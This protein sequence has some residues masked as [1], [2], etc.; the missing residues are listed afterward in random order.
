MIFACS[1]CGRTMPQSR[2]ALEIA[3]GWTV[4]RVEQHNDKDVSIGYLYL[5]PNDMLDTKS[6][7]VELSLKTTTQNSDSN[8][9]PKLQ[10]SE[11][12]TPPPTEFP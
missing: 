12:P 9:T 7:Q 4:V 2:G 10:T 5:C 6:K 11:P 8:V 3:I 1:H